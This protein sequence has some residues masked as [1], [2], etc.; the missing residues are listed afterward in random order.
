MQVQVEKGNKTN[1]LFFYCNTV[2]CSAELTA[3]KAFHRPTKN[4]YI[5]EGKQIYMKISMYPTSNPDQ[6][7]RPYLQHSRAHRV[8][9]YALTHDWSVLP[10]EF[11]Q[12][13]SELD[14]LVISCCV[15][16]ASGSRW[17]KCAKLWDLGLEF[18]KNVI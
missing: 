1:I 16:K 9:F 11:E 18:C 15:L 10:D 6:A 5:N 17:T 7:K 13:R 2:K 8:L 3:W 14:L 4:K 12:V